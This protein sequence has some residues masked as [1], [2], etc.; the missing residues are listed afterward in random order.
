M[1]A[2]KRK[3]RRNQRCFSR[4]DRSG[5]ILPTAGMTTRATPA[6]SA[7]RSFSGEN[8]P[9]SP[10]TRPR[11]PAETLL[12]RR[13]AW[14]QIR[15]VLARPV[16]QAPAADDPALDLLQPQLAAELDRL[17]RPAADRAVAP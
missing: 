11:R 13:Q 7:S 5:V 6:A 9:R 10:V 12:V 14:Q 16:E 17:A 3:P 8:T 2:R 15:G 4:R 1:P